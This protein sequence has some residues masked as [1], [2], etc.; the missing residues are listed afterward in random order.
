[1][2]GS[3]KNAILTHTIHDVTSPFGIMSAIGLND[4]YAL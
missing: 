2:R 4:I 3:N 1:M